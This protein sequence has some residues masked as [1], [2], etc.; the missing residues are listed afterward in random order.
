MNAKEIKDYLNDLY[1]GKKYD[2]YSYGGER[3]S[4]W[5]AASDVKKMIN[6]MLPKEVGISC[7]EENNSTKLKLYLQNT[8]QPIVRTI[9]RISVSKTKGDYIPGYFGSGHY[10]WIVKDIN[11]KL[12][13]PNSLYA[14]DEV[15][16]RTVVDEWLDKIVNEDSKNKKFEARVLEIN[17]VIKEA[18]KNFNCDYRSAIEFI[19]KHKHQLEEN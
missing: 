7:D 6:G 5:T 4:S 12:Y 15:D 3:I 10:E 1:V 9:A 11:V 13:S 14:V 2:K 19:Y 8:L 17:K 18:C 16:L